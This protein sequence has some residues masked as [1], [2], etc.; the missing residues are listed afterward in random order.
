MFS[1]LSVGE[2]APVCDPPPHVDSLPPA[3]IDLSLRNITSTHLFS[4]VVV[5]QIIIKM[6]DSKACW[7]FC[8]I[9]RLCLSRTGKLFGL[10]LS[11]LAWQ[12]CRDLDLLQ[13]CKIRAWF[14]LTSLV[15]LQLIA[16]P[17][18]HFCS[19]TLESSDQFLRFDVTCY[20]GCCC[21]SVCRMLTDLKQAEK[22]LH[23]EKLRV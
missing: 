21:P 8:L 9:K 13:E 22:S 23:K 6:T 4:Y 2:L 20:F 19:N 16:L 11:T 5:K 1:L 12:V 15:A 18:F 10:L 17:S 7:L 3:N 14:T